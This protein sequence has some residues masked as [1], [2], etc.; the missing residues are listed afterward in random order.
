MQPGAVLIDVSRGGVVDQT[1]LAAALTNG[2]LRG[3]ALMYS[4]LSHC[5]KTARSGISKTS[6]SPRIVRR[7]TK[8]GKLK[9]V[10][11]FSEN[12]SRYRRGDPLFNIVDPGR[13]Y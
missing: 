12:L 9:S 7:S 5:P 6:F 1:A 3:A 2:Q 8:A 13:G 4:K 11:M 10:A